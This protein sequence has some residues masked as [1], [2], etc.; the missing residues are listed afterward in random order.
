MSRATNFR[1]LVR[2]NFVEK[3]EVL[4]FI[5]VP[6]DVETAGKKEPTNKKLWSPWRR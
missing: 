5:D 3:D 2:G 1:E 6:E 4:Y